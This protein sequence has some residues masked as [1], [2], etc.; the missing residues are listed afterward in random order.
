MY[1]FQY[2]QLISCS[3]KIYIYI[4]IIFIKYK[5][6]KAAYLYLTQSK[7]S[8]CGDYSK[9]NVLLRQMYVQHMQILFTYY[10]T[11]KLRQPKM[12]WEPYMYL[13]C[14]DHSTTITGRNCTCTICCQLD[15]SNCIQSETHD[16]H[17]TQPWVS[18]IPERIYAYCCFILIF[19]DRFI[20]FA[21]QRFQAL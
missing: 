4:Y 10:S 5:V 13:R 19:N 21:E 7:H 18:S 2:T 12:L 6:K 8:Q 17:C 14:I 9:Q 15:T 20:F 3:K 11:S 1:F 16:L